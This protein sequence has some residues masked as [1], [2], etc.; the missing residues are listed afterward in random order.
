M[1][2][3]EGSPMHRP[4]QFVGRS[5]VLLASLSLFSTTVPSPSEGRLTFVHE[6]GPS[7]EY[8]LIGDVAVSPDNRFVYIPTYPLDRIE[9]FSRSPATGDIEEVF[10]TDAAVTAVDQ[11]TISPDGSSLYTLGYYDGAVATFQRDLTT[12]AITPIQFLQPGPGGSPTLNQAQDMV[13][14]PDGKNLYVT[15]SSSST[16]VVYAR[17]PATGLLGFVEA[18]VEGTAGVVGLKGPIGIDFSPDG[19]YAYVAC[20]YAGG[21]VVVFRRDPATGRLAFVQDYQDGEGGVNLHLAF[22][23]ATSPDGL[24]VYVTVNGGIAQFQR[25]PT[26]GTLTYLQ[27]TADGADHAVAISADGSR[28][29]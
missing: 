24:N 12:G 17:D 20:F 16:V 11:L 29:S 19:L 21:G 26:A 25:D 15:A 28:V 2:A 6:A 9:A 1:A 18:Q 8:G 4:E 27:T 10:D 23:V 22:D 7:S 5:I 13:V 14:S 3:A